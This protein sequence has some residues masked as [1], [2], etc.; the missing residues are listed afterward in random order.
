M[1]VFLKLVRGLDQLAL[2]LLVLVGLL[3]FLVISNLT[4]RL[5]NEEVYYAAIDS[6]DLYNRIYEGVLVDEALAS[7]ND[8]LLGGVQL[9]VHQQAV[10]ALREMNNDN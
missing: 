9:D 10:A 2:G 6:M 4:E 7:Q 5:V 3:H 8:N 1:V